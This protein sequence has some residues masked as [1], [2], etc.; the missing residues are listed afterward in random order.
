MLIHF[1]LGLYSVSAPSTEL[2]CKCGL[3]CSSNYNS[4]SATAASMEVREMVLNAILQSICNVTSPGCCLA[5]AATACPTHCAPP[6]HPTRRCRGA[7]LSPTSVPTALPI[8]LARLPP[9]RLARIASTPLRSGM[10][11]LARRPTPSQAGR[12]PLS[13]AFTRSRTASMPS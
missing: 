8:A 2:N 4:C 13:T 3:G 10:R 5:P 1:V 9:P 7:R 6:G 11:R 12:D